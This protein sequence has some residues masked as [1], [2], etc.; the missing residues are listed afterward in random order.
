[1]LYRLTYLTLLIL[2][3]LP[4]SAVEV[5]S[6]EQ[7]MDFGE[8]AANF[9]VTSML[10]VGF[11]G[12]VLTSGPLYVISSPQPAHFRLTGYPANQALMVTISDFQLDRGSGDVFWIRNFVHN[13][14]V[15]DGAGNALLMIGA[16]LHVGAGNSY[17]DTNY[18]GPIQVDISY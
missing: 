10:N 7:S 2:L 17:P 6:E 4:A 1:M 9:S 5:I 13:N 3:S 8:F 16:T 12:D 18:S 15:T 14:L 11:T